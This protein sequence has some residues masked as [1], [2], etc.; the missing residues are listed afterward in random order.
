MAKQNKIS[1]AYSTAISKRVPI[2]LGLI[3]IILILTVGVLCTSTYINNK[4]NP[5]LSLEED[6]SKIVEHTTIEWLNENKFG[7]NEFYFSRFYLEDLDGNTLENG[8]I[9]FKVD[10]GNKKDD[11]ISGDNVTISTTACYNWANE[12]FASTSTSISF[13][14]YSE[15]LSIINIDATFD[16]KPFFFKKIDLKKDVYFVTTFQVVELVDGE[17]ITMVYA[18]TQDYNDLLNSENTLFH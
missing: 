6:S 17:S 2:M 10:L 18:V 7:I 5:L 8:S 13:K 14:G 15:R 16:K 11:A 12:S 3:G 1:S 4:P 9:N